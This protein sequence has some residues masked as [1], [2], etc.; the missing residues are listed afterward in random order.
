MKTL[1]DRLYSKVER[2]PLTDCLNWTASKFKDGYGQIKINYKNMKTHRVSYQLHYGVDP[3][4]LCVCHKC[5]NPACVNPQHLFLGTPKDNTQDMVGKGRG[6]EQKKT[7]CKNGHEYNEENTYRYGTHRMCR[8]C[9]AVQKLA[10]HRVAQRKAY[11][12]MRR[13]INK[14][15]KV[16]KTHCKH[17]HEFNNE[18]TR[19]WKNQRICKVCQK[20]SQSKHRAKNE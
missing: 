5:D 13:S 1:L 9:Q 4:D 11:D 16:K 3:L 14:N 7:H 2:D 6:K 20:F 17:G 10:P 19:Y 12:K 8:I 15:I 18:N